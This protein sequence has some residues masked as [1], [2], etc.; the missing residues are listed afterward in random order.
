MSICCDKQFL[1]C[2]NQQPA[3]KETFGAT[4]LKISVLHFQVFPK[5]RTHDSFFFT[6]LRERGASVLTAL[7][8]ILLADA[9]SQL[10]HVDGWTRNTSYREEL[11]FKTVLDW[12]FPEDGIEMAFFTAWVNPSHQAQDCR[13]AN[14]KLNWWFGKNSNVE[15][16]TTKSYHQ[17]IKQ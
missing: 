3:F 9:S 7:E 4:E 11:K 17:E 5:K 14:M 13:R 10:F 12:F 2:W 6:N 16:H 8:F 1:S 15:S